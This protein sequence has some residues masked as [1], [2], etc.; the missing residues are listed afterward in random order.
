MCESPYTLCST[1]ST[2]TPGKLT[3]ASKPSLS[4]INAPAHVLPP[5]PTLCLPFV[6]SLLPPLPGSK[7]QDDDDEPES[8]HE[9]QGHSSDSEGQQEVGVASNSTLKMDVDIDS[10]CK[11]LEVRNYD[12]LVDH[13]RTLY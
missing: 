4:L 7:G 6:T 5:M 8:M 11:D 10:E 9:E 3:K 13:F 1:V 2:V 12:W